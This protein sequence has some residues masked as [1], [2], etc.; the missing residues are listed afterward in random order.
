MVCLSDIFKL[1]MKDRLSTALS[2]LTRAEVRMSPDQQKSIK[3]FWDNFDDFISNFFIFDKDNADF[4]L[5]KLSRGQMFSGS[6]MKEKNEA[7]HSNKQLLE[8]LTAE[9]EELRKRM[10][11]VGARKEKLI[12]DWESL[13]TESR[14]AK[15]EYTAQEKKLAEAEEK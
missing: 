8:R 7:H 14:E 13:M 5:Q 11:E 10:A 3:A 6:A 1:N 9:E 15:S 12:S 2:T 4:E